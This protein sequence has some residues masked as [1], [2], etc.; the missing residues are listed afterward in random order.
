MT[1]S[2]TTNLACRYCGYDMRGLTFV[3]NVAR[4]PECGRMTDLPIL[5]A[6]LVDQHQSRVSDHSAAIWAVIMFDAFLR[7]V[8]KRSPFQYSA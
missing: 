6:D 4:C 3:E 5:A 7:Q 2:S 8:D 1:D